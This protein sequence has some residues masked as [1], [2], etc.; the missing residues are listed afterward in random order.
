MA[1]LAIS[2]RNVSYYISGKAILRS[3]DLDIYANE[4]VAL[5]GPNGS[6]KS[7]LIRIIRGEARP[8]TGTEHRCTLFGM[9][10]WNLFKLRSLIGVVSPELERAISPH[11]KAWDLVASGLFQSY[12]LFRNHAL[13]SEQRRRITDS[14][15]SLGLDHLAERE[16]GT[17]STGEMR[18]ILIARALVNDPIML[19]LDEPM[20]GLDIIAKK[21]FR[22]TISLLANSGKGIIIATHDMEDIVPE[23]KRVVM[24]KEGRIFLDAPKEEALTD[25]VMT[26]LFGVD[27]KVIRYGDNY[28]ASVP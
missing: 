26:E 5:L 6:G 8:W 13:S 2:F 16:V 18:R 23:I 3:I 15:S 21:A 14:I 27:V 11:T 4:S 10:R 25:P 20:T 22:E 19:V 24:L 9:E 1:P 7:S 17:L 28:H 12:D